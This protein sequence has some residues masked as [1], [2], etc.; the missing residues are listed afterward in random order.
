MQTYISSNIGLV[1]ILLFSIIMIQSILIFIVMR[2]LKTLTSIASWL[3]LFERFI[4]VVFKTE[5]EEFINKKKK[6]FAEEVLKHQQKQN[7]YKMH[8]NN[9]ASSPITSSG[10]W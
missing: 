6:E 8:K 4:S 10:R 9:V 1:A 3:L 7:L 5:I 2:R